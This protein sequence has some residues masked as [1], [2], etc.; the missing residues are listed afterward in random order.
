MTQNIVRH[1]INHQ[2]RGVYEVRLVDGTGKMVGI[3]SFQEALASAHAQNMDLVEMNRN[4]NPPVCKILDYGKFKYE[5][6]KA[7]K[8]ARKNQFIQETKELTLRPVTDTHDLLVKAG[9]VKEW[10]E[11]G[12]KV[13]II[14]RLK[15]RE[16]AH[17]EQATEIINKLLLSVGPHKVE[18][19]PRADGR[20]VTAIIGP[21]QVQHAARLAAKA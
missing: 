16:K 12:N 19:Q 9:H 11:E 13:Q 7:Q 17:P 20:N 2:I 14:V 8:L 5:Q 3:V 6:S 10:L 15:G 21:I 18:T 4:N 1:R